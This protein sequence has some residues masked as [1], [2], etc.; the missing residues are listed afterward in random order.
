M[1]YEVI[2]TYAYIDALMP[3]QGIADTECTP[4]QQSQEHVPSNIHS[5]LVQFNGLDTVVLGHLCT[6]WGTEVVYKCISIA[7]FITLCKF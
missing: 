2:H 6:D 1:Y 4:S 5:G 7:V 3:T